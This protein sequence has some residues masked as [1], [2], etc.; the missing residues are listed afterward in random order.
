MAVPVG[1][2][3]KRR[4]SR[5]MTGRMAEIKERLKGVTPPSRS[6]RTVKPAS[7]AMA[8]HRRMTGGRPTPSAPAKSLDTLRAAAASRGRSRTSGGSS[9]PGTGPTPAT[10]PSPRTRGKSAFAASRTGR[11]PA[12]GARRQGKTPGSPRTGPGR[13]ERGGPGGLVGTP[14]P[15]GSVGSAPKVGA[16]RLGRA[17]SSATTG[18]PKV[19]AKKLGRSRSRGY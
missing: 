19:G 15:V 9:T 6:G 13:I 4:R 10:T 16:A 3:Y 18:T 17:R 8:P 11:P 14:V 12:H 7:S 1:R 5:K 2:G